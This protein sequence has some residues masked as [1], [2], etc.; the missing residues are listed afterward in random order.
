MGALE[1]ISQSV[2]IV[3]LQYYFGYFLV[4][5]VYLKI[6]PKET[7][8]KIGAHKTPIRALDV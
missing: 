2:N 5:I 7:Q 8:H 1:N 6:G 4:E 3:L